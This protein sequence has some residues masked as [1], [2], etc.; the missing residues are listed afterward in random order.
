MGME[1]GV[2]RCNVCCMC[3]TPSASICVHLWKPSASIYDT[4]CGRLGLVLRFLGMLRRAELPLPIMH[5]YDD[6]IA[7]GE[8][9]L[10]QVQ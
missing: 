9:A 8:A 2:W 7:F 10:Q 3:H 1:D 6:G 5:V 4:G